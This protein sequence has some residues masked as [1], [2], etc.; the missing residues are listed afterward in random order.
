VEQLAHD[1]DLPVSTVR[2]YQTR[3]LL[4][5]PRREGRVAYYGIEHR[6]RLRA[7]ADLQARGFSLAA[8]KELLDGAASGQSLEAVL[9]LATASST[10]HRE[11]PATLSLAELLAALPGVEPTP[12]LIERIIG[13]G[14]VELG[15]DG[16]VVVE[17]PTFL[18]IGSRLMRLGVPG[19]VVLDEYEHLRGLTDDVADRFTDVFRRS[20]WASFEADGLPAE[21]VGDVIGV[22]EELGPLAEAVVTVTLRHSLQAA[23][24]QFL[25]EQAER[26]GLELPH[27]GDAPAG[28]TASDGEAR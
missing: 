23:A 13:L 3:G 22:L 17:S 1:H 8:I 6:T 25:D 4:P 16:T 7:I 24:Q 21:R 2:L 18:D 15:T 26:L 19:D 14:L 28:A 10:W 20:F 11:P 27:P 12:E 5:P 9:G